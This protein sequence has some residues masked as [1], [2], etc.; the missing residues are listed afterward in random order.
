MNDRAGH[1]IG[2]FAVDL[3][4]AVHRAWVH[5]DR[6]WFGVGELF[7]GETEAVIILA[8]GGDKPAI[9]ALFLEPEHHYDIDAFKPFAHVVKDF[10]A[11]L[12]NLARH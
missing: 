2:N 9:H 1:V 3:N 5:D 10:D 7:G 4:A 11:K 8:L 12:V 6:I